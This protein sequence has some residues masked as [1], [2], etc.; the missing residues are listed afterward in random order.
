MAVHELFGCN[1]RPVTL[2]LDVIDLW[3]SENHAVVADESPLCNHQL[4]VVQLVVVIRRQCL[5]GI[6]ILVQILAGKVKT[7][8]QM[9]SCAVCK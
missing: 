5:L 4:V 6:E 9:H 1:T 7:S 3:P 2:M 8:D